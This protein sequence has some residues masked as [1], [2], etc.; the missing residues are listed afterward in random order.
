VSSE[1]GMAIVEYDE[2]KI[3]MEKIRYLINSEGYQVLL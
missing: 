3:G 2:K 1:K